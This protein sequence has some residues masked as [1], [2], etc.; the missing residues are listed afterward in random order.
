MNWRSNIISTQSNQETKAFC[1]EQLR[2]T[3]N[4]LKTE[5]NII[6]DASF[7]EV[8]SEEIESII[9]ELKDISKDYSIKLSK[10]NPGSIII[11]LEGSEEGFK[12]IQSLYKEGKLTEV[13]GLSVK[14]VGYELPNSNT[15]NANIQKKIDLFFSYSHKDE[16]LRSQLANHLSALQQNGKIKGW[17]DRQIGAGREWQGEIH[18]YLETSHIILLL[19]S[20]DFIA[21][22]YCYDI[23]V[24]RAME[25]HDL[26][27]ARVIPIILR[28]VDWEDTPFA[29]LQVLPRGGVPV[30]TW[31]N[32]DEAFLD[33]SRG[34]RVAVDEISLKCGNED[35]KTFTSQ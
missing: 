10:S 21:S 33:V 6:L 11:T 3:T 29:R 8:T 13:M 2:E 30:S 27:E 24:R 7:E 34:I 20:A 31:N 14:F 28:P 4:T 9:K 1:L 17:H 15:K 23:E 16:H 32:Q 22:K 26:G 25:R 19:V 35:A 5:W 12:V 18:H